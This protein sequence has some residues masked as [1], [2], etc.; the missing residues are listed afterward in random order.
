MTALLPAPGDRGC[1]VPTTATLGTIAARLAA[2]GPAG[3]SSA[4][5][6]VSL[7]RV[8]LSVD[9]DLKNLLKRLGMGVAFTSAADFTGL[10]PQACCIGLVQQAAT[11]QVGEQGTVASAASAVGIVASAG[12]IELPPVTFDRPYLML[13]TDS[14]TGEPLFITRVADPAPGALPN[15]L[16]PPGGWRALPGGSTTAR[17]G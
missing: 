7:P 3:K 8:N 15:P 12:R 14:T 5:R 16:R 9:T 1:A 13:V 17:S 11:L 4:M 10:S 2:G 6:G